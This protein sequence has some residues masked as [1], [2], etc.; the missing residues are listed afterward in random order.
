MKRKIIAITLIMV[1]F[2]TLAAS[3]GIPYNPKPNTSKVKFKDVSAKHW[4][5]NTIYKLAAQK[6]KTFSGYPDETFKPD[7]NMT[8]AEFITALVRTLGY[9]ASNETL[10]TFQDVYSDHWASKYIGM[11]QQRGIIEPNDYGDTLRPDEIITRLEACKMLINSYQRTKLA[12]N[13][14]SIT[15]YPTFKDAAGLSQKDKKIVHILAR[16]G[17]LKG[18]DNGIAGL[19]YYATRAELAAFILRF[20]ENSDKLENYIVTQEDTQERKAHYV[21]SYWTTYNELLPEYTKTVKGNYARNPELTEKINSLEFFHLDKSYNGK[22]KSHFNKLNAKY[23]KYG[24]PFDINLNDANVIA[25]NVTVTYKGKIKVGWVY[26]SEKFLRSA[27]IFDDKHKELGYGEIKDV[28][29]EQHLDASLAEKLNPLNNF[30]ESSRTRTY[31]LI[32]FV[33]QLPTTGK[34]SIPGGRSMPNATDDRVL[35]IIY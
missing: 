8:R 9:P 11:A 18:Y 16:K 26:D 21:G 17:I 10:A 4:A 5:K 33:K 12:V 27:E 13:D 23:K 32:G 2:T 19:K 14:N 15:M 31:S 6:N 34:I 35:N 30:T 24:N 22:Y 29:A 3:A 25:L 1:F 20:I 7:A 28:Y